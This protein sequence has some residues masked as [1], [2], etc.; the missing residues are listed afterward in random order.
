M[1]QIIFI[2]A[3]VSNY[4]YTYLELMAL[5]CGSYKRNSQPFCGDFAKV[6]VQQLILRS[7]ENHEKVLFRVDSLIHVIA[8]TREL[9]N[10]LSGTMNC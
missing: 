3:N 9:E 4:I 10:E 7:V 1:I 6:Q 8:I 2:Y 5:D